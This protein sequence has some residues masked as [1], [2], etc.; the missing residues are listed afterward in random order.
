MMKHRSA[1]LALLCLSSSGLAAHAAGNPAERGL[2]RLEPK[3]MMMQVCDIRMV[4]DVTRDKR[5]ARADRAMVDAM[6]RPSI[7]D[8]TVRGQGGAFRLKGRWVQF[9]FDCTL[10]PDHLKTVAFS[11]QV[12]DEIPEDQW[13]KFGLWR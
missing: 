13:E 4:Q 7:E 9:S 10:S 8:D 5:Y 3:T 11:Y 2:L 12:G 1:A 6:S